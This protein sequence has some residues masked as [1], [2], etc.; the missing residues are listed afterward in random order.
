M[1]P[2]ALQPPYLSLSRPPTELGVVGCSLSLLSLAGFGGF[3]LLALA[4]PLL[5]LGNLS[6]VLLPRLAVATFHLRQPVP[7]I[8]SVRR[9]EVLQ[10][11]VGLRR[12]PK[13]PAS[14]PVLPILFI[15]LGVGNLQI[16]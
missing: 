15:Y 13:V 6:P 8:E 4:L 16:F 10:R 12:R 14:T 7:V 5:G 1:A 3:A 9:H 2:C 11:D